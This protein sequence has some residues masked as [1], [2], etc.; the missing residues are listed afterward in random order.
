MFKYIK[1]LFTKP[2]IKGNINGKGEKVYHVP[3]GMLYEATKAEQMFHTEE[4][5]IKAGFRKS[6][7]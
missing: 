4:D 5:A 1:R 7:R 6:R 3:G 2:T